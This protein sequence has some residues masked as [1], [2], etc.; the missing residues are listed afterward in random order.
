MEVS[1][2]D[3]ALQRINM[4]EQRIQSL[5]SFAQGPD[6][7]FQKILDSSI[8]NQKNPESASRSEIN[9]LI[10]KYANKNGL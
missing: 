1:G 3:I 9:D 5:N 4:I 10:T 8:K 6:T 2:L 7:D